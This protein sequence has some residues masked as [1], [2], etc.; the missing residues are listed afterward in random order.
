MRIVW[1]VD[2][3][4][5]IQ[6]GTEANPPNFDGKEEMANKRGVGYGGRQADRSGTD[7]NGRERSK[8]GM[9]YAP[10]CSWPSC[11]PPAGCLQASKYKREG[12]P[13]KI[14]RDGEQGRGN[15]GRWMGYGTV[16]YVPLAALF[17]SAFLSRAIL[18]FWPLPPPMAQEPSLSCP[19]LSCKRR[20]RRRRG[21]EELAGSPGA[22]GE[23]GARVRA[24][25]GR[26]RVLPLFTTRILYSPPPP[27]FLK[28]FQL[29][30]FF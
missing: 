6:P 15:R 22:R 7:G 2:W 5:R 19:V 20:R 12:N 30:L 29:L 28:T 9:G 8:R 27:I 3:I 18:D 16:R 11:W 14:R 25:D 4:C 1:W 13:W 23:G 24:A 17:F 21:E 10:G 26:G